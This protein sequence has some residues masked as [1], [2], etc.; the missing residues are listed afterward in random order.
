MEPLAPDSYAQFLA[1]LKS[2]IQAA[3]LRASVAVNRELVLLYW[4]IG[5]DILDRQQRALRSSIAW[6]P[7]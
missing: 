6:L 5:R 3:H 4:Q 7:T 1:D 2:R